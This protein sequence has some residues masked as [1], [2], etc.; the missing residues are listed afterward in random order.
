[1]THD[2][3]TIHF[4]SPV[5][6]SD[7]WHQEV[8]KTPNTKKK[9]QQLVFKKKTETIKSFFSPPPHTFWFGPTRPELHTI[10]TSRSLKTPQFALI[11]FCTDF[12]MH[13]IK[14]FQNHKKTPISSRS[15]HHSAGAAP[16]YSLASIKRPSRCI[17]IAILSMLRKLMRIIEL[18]LGTRQVDPICSCYGG[19]GGAWGAVCSLRSLLQN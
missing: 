6:N 1:M 9:Q 16:I 19:Y 13:G 2:Y 18:P 15:F 5:R 11:K 8:E 10:N 4:C 7:H 12:I 3:W 17:E 14:T